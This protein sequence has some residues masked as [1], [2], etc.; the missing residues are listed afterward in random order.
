[1]LNIKS[2]FLGLRQKKHIVKVTEYQKHCD[3]Q[4]KGSV[5]VTVCRSDFAK[6]SNSN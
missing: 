5:Y 2:N 1:M 4:F 3:V 6:K